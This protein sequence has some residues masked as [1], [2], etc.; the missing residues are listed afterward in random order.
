M[1]YPEPTKRSADT[2]PPPSCEDTQRQFRLDLDPDDTNNLQ[3]DD[4][5]VI[6]LDDDGYED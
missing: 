4:G 5:S 3:T 1:M 2:L 6:I